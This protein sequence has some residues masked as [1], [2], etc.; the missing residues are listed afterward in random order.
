MDWK[1]V[2]AIF[3]IVFVKI[4][5]WFLKHPKVLIPIGLVVV[6]MVG[7]RACNRPSNNPAQAQ[8]QTL[9]PQQLK[10]PTVAEAP[11]VLQTYSRVYYV[12]KFAAY[13]GPKSYLNVVP[14]GPTLADKVILFTWYEWQKNKWVLQNSKEGVPFDKPVTGDFRL[15]PR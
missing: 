9:S 13:V 12:A 2:E 8:T 5:G 4:P 15:F 1:V 7:Y 14:P 6:A 3:I 10:A 11:T